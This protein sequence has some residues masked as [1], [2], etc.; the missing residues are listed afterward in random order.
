LEKEKVKAELS[1]HT[2]MTDS[3]AENDDADA[4]EGEGEGDDV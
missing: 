4:E 3:E 2:G 1:Q